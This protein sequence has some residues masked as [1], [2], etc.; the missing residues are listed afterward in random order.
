M[1]K[2]IS[3]LTFSTLCGA[4]LFAQTDNTP[5]TWTD[6]TGNV[7]TSAGFTGNVGIGITNPTAKLHISETE[8][9]TGL[10]DFVLE[11]VGISGANNRLQ[12]A[13]TNTSQVSS[14]TNLSAGSIL[15]TKENA[16]SGNAP[17]PDMGFSANGIDYQ[18]VIKNN[19][20][21]GMGTLPSARLHLRSASL[22]GNA[23][24]VENSNSINLFNVQNDGN[25]GIGTTNATQPLQIG[26]EFV[27][28]S[29]GT[30]YIGRNISYTNV[31]GT[32]ANRT[33]K[34][35]QASALIALSGNG[36]IQFETNNNSTLAAGT[37]IDPL[38][39]G[40]VNPVGMKQRLVI[41]PNGQVSI[42]DK[43]VTTGPHTDYKLSVDGKIVAKEAV[44][45]I[46]DWADYVFDVNYQLPSLSEVREYVAKNKH[47]PNIPPSSE[48]IVEG[49]DVS[50]MATKQQE[51]IEE[52]FLYILQL[53]NR[54]KLLE[55][56]Q[57][58]IH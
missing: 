1:K 5:D 44:I 10:T 3:I 52:L 45:Q 38:I 34:A 26:D 49:L 36:G 56:K 48:M 17:A 43:K 18:L 37:N 40:N 35:N 6:L 50:K 2:I 22:I 33:L 11:K 16:V 8:T 4:S 20:N 12:I 24:S 54:I 14:G 58:N 28:H 25:V 7:S 57:E 23:F 53:E 13:I 46:T 55:N 9:G 32:Y 39:N 41:S 27:F 15:F 42:G 31:S 51:K 30:K 21:V 19:G 47:L 29:G